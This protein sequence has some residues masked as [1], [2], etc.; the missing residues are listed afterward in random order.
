MPTR[1]KKITEEKAV[2][3]KTSPFKDYADFEK[4]IRDFANR[5]KTIVVNQAKRTSDYFEMTCFNY[6]IRFYELNGYTLEVKNL[7][8]GKYRYKCTP[9]GIQSNFSHFEAS[10]EID[11]KKHYFEIQHN[12]AA[13]SSQDEA[14]F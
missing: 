2:V 3:K 1:S 10:I 5:Y 8:G 4:E 12:L 14:I 6:I 11:K 7:Q 9:A 13:Q